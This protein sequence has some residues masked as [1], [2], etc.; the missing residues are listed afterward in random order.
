M[1][2]IE[3]P[4]QFQYVTQIELI[5]IADVEFNNIYAES[6]LITWL[7]K[8]RE[9]IKILAGGNV[10]VWIQLNRFLFP[11]LDIKMPKNENPTLN[12]SYYGW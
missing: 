11:L 1:L 2:P 8:I 5:K 7:D 10:S 9:E 6:A 12:S 3:F 4:T